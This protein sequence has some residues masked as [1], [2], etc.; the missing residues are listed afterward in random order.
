MNLLDIIEATEAR[1][2]GPQIVSENNNRGSINFVAGLSDP[3]EMIRC[4]YLPEIRRRDGEQDQEYAD[5]IRPIVMA[6]PV[7]EREKILNA[8]LRRANL[9]GTADGR[10]AV[11]V[12]G[13]PAWHG[14]GTNVAEAVSSADAIRLA[15]LDNW[16]L[17]KIQLFA[18]FNGVR[19]PTDAHAIVRGDIGKALGTVGNRYEI[20]DNEQAFDFMDDVIGTGAEFVTAGALGDGEK[21]WIL[22]KMPEIVEVLPGDVVESYILFTNSHDGSSAINIFPTSDRVV[23]QNTLRVAVNAKSKER[24]LSFRHTKNAAKNVEKAQQAIGISRRSFES[25]AENAQYLAKTQLDPREYF[26]LCLDDI[27]DTTVADQKVTAAALGN[28]SLLNAIADLSNVEERQTEQKKLER[29]EKK[30]SALLADILERYETDCNSAFPGAE[31]TAWAALNAVTEYADHGN[32]RYNGTTEER[33]E[34]RFES[35]IYGRADDIK[36]SALSLAL[37]MTAN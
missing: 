18:D 29:V 15:G 1:R 8:A 7:A 6:L 19:I 17:E 31:G 23:C 30:R 27:L 5:R 2:A 37:E 36:Q 28:G 9:G 22:A 21:V 34:R 35:A 24:S 14:L 33:R 32:L 25:F 20:F 13:E 16:N 10:I 11:M 4:G 12:A 3:G 26:A